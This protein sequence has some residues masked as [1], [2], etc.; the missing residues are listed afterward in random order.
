MF[1]YS[2]SALRSLLESM[3]CR[4]KLVVLSGVWATIKGLGNN[5]RQ[6]WKRGGTSH[7]WKEAQ[8]PQ[9]KVHNTAQEC[10]TTGQTK[11]NNAVEPPTISY[12]IQTHVTN[13]Q[14][15][16][17][18]KSR[19]YGMQPHNLIQVPISNTRQDLRF[20]YI[21]ARSVCNKSGVIL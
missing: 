7:K 19:N 4:S 1:T 10:S 12:K 8:N 13:R 18:S 2:T 21:N 20:I 14:I 15:N 17:V 16:T 6:R 9:P 5:K 11:V 3:T